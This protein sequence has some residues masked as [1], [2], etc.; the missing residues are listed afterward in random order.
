MARALVLGDSTAVPYE[1][2][3]HLRNAGVAHLLAVSGLHVTLVAG[4]FRTLMVHCLLFIPA[5]RCRWDCRR[6]GAALAVP[7][8]LLFAGFAGGSSSAWRA[9]ITASLHWSLLAAGRRPDGRTV[10]AAAACILGAVSPGEV[11][12]PGF[13]LSIVATAALL[14]TP[15]RRQQER[16]PTWNAILGW[17]QQA[18]TMSLR[19]FLATAPIVYG[20]FGSLP[21]VGI[22][23]NVILIPPAS[24]IWIP[25]A[26]I[27]AC[28]CSTGLP[29]GWQITGPLFE[30]TTDLMLAACKQ[31]SLLDLGATLPPPTALQVIAVATTSLTLLCF[32]GKTRYYLVGLAALLWVGGE[33]HLRWAER[34]PQ[35]LRV[36]FVDVGQGDAALIDFPDG[37]LALIDAGGW[38]THNSASGKQA[39]QRNTGQRVL[40]PLLAARRKRRL[41]LAVLTHGHPDHYGGMRE[42][43]ERYPPR[44]LWLSRQSEEENPGGPVSLLT[45]AASAK[46]AAI[47]HPDFLCEQPVHFG[48][49]TVEVLAPCP[50]YDPGFEPK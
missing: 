22:L 49:A 38:L 30:Q 6:L 45:Q 11:T 8:V 26:V 19:T 33:G 18:F 12:S 48:R 1:T 47:R 27:H 14:G 2:R 7:A 39:T 9:A 35:R 4:T 24:L 16:H 42:L 29:V 44:S 17:L 5:L 37:S 20:C 3:S 34:F 10:A 40:L 41:D 25:L 28:L 31:L 32:E 23:A 43:F 46:G 50:R 13:I 36:T 15:K 21:L